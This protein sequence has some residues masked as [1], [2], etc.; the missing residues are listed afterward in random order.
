[1]ALVTHSKQIRFMMGWLLN[2]YINSQTSNSTNY[3]WQDRQSCSHQLITPKN[4]INLYMQKATKPYLDPSSN[5]THKIWAQHI[6]I[7]N[8]YQL[9]LHHVCEICQCPIILKQCLWI[10][11]TFGI[12]YAYKNSN[13]YIS[14]LCWHNRLRPNTCK[15]S[16]CKNH[17][18]CD[19][20]LMKAASCPEVWS[21]WIIQSK[22]LLWC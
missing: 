9:L 13:I 11:Y 22:L 15:S 5:H 19:C 4:T 14:K 8:S 1:M 21:C 2:C 6:L 3:K 12:R 7:L 16:E 20:H 18:M 10:P 17:V